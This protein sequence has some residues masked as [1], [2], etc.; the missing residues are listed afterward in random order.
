MSNSQRSAKKPKLAQPL[1]KHFFPGQTLLTSPDCDPD[2]LSSEGLNKYPPLSQPESTEPQHITPQ[3]TIQV[4]HYL[5][6]YLVAKGT[7]CIGVV[8]GG[9]GVAR[10]P[11]I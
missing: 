8:T 6:P 4:G 11:Q 1:L 7:H 9:A 10:T 2:S 5:Y 3:P